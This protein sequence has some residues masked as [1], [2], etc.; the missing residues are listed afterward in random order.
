MSGSADQG[1]ARR[2][3]SILTPGQRR[4]LH[5]VLV[6]SVL[7]LANSAYLL[8]TTPHEA[9]DR[10]AQ[11]TYD[12]SP[13]GRAGIGAITAPT[14]AP[15]ERDIPVFYQVM[16]LAH[17]F[18]AGLAIVVAL[19]FV[20]WHLANALRRHNQRAVIFGIAVVAAT[21]AL[22]VSGLFILTQ[23]SSLQ[24]RWIYRSH[25]ILAGLVPLLYLGHRVVSY[26]PPRRRA[27]WTGV[28]AVAALVL[29]F[30]GL[31]A[32]LQS[33]DSW[34]VTPVH[35]M[36]APETPPVADPFTP[37]RPTHLGYPGSK[38]FPSAAGTT[39]GDYITR[40]TLTQDD[41]A[42]QT[43]MEADL[44]TY[45]FLL[46][47]QMG[48]ATCDRCHPSVVEQW[49]HS[50]HRF[51]SFNNPFYK[52]S[53]ENLRTEKDGHLRSQ[54]CG[55]CH[56]PNLMFAGKMLGEVNPL[57]P[58][59]QA[60]L[61]CLAC[62]A[63]DSIHGKAGNG[64]YNLSDNAPDPYLF[65]NAKSGPEQQLHDMLIKSKPTVHKRQM[66]KPF[67]RSSEY[68]LTCHKVSLDLP[69]NDYRW[70]RGQ[71]EYD[72]WH[73]SG[74]ARNAART[75]YLP[76]QRKVCQDCHMPLEEAVR[77]EVSAKNGMVR[78]HRFLAVNTA[79]PY[80]RGD[81]DTIQRT[82][83]F[84]RKEKMIVDV[85]ALRRISGSGEPGEPIPALDK[86][87]PG[88]AAGEEVE[89]E[90]VVRNK[91]V[92]HTFPGGTNDSNEGWID[93]E[94]RD[95]QGQ[96]LTRSGAL[97]ADGR[98]D[99]EAHMYKVL[100]VDRDSHAVLK[101]DPQNFH[102]VVYA[103]VI[104]PGS[105]D[106][107][108]YRLR[109]P[110]EAAG[111]KLTITASLKWRKFN[112]EFTD[113]VFA[114]EKLPQIPSLAGKTVPEL[115]VTEIAS[116]QVTLAVASTASAPD[117]AKLSADDWMRFNDYGIA[118]WVQGSNQLANWAFGKEAELAPRR[119]DG[120]RNLAR[121]AVTEGRVADAI[122]LL[123]RCEALAP[124][125]ARTAWFWALTKKKQG[126][127]G[128]AEKALE[129]V[130]AYFPEDR[131]AWQEL[132]HTR[133]LDGRYDEAL[134]AFLEVLAIDPED[135]PAHY[136]RML[137]YRALGDNE[138]AAEA[139][140]AYDK[141][142]LDDSQA[143]VTQRFRLER[144]IDNREWQTIHVHGAKVAG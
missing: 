56:D 9:P 79:L 115:P 21:L 25:Q 40:L 53:V 140:K 5:V 24:H 20:V 10:I 96:V 69:V 30:I 37:F 91:G 38:F 2:G 124:G 29:V 63:I 121:V 87:Q 123:E 75:F 92:G 50:A 85:F 22:A 59:S 62:H 34:P 137:T 33:K 32:Y 6:A 16:L 49:S 35:A 12:V 106:L 80:V 17:I 117:L 46:N 104:G 89:I 86:T 143:E 27:I 88:L 71:N 65:R 99:P 95:D 66:L 94:V 19:A 129:R 60:G 107:V 136:W 84:L 98:V 82:E 102:A 4:L 125:D 26:V 15:P 47:G 28:F 142:K 134:K 14:L 43:V 18:G 76:E 67:F 8:L 131:Q 109:V 132:G 135:R 61:T 70:L 74:V 52:A 68:C 55:G 72:N 13:F 36:G 23:A 58:E 119:I 54:W 48:S 42:P 64:N 77:A 7:I 97:G 122:A 120:P 31:H 44:K 1:A 78:S 110:A 93:F 108:H 41:L 126:L 139:A 57:W 83:E 81:Q 116:A 45:G 100:F 138:H 51:S 113:F 112:P 133:Y 128:E 105:D 114:R 3:K 11:G 111:R 144:P 39:T 130:L 118:N 127:Y 101:R 73:D 103:H 141:Y 90:V